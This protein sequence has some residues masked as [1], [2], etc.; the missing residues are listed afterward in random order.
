MRASFSFRL[1][2]NQVGEAFSNR[3]QVL[4]HREHETFL[5]SGLRVGD[6][7]TEKSGFLAQDEQF[8]ILRAR[9]PA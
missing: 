7:A 8:Q 5:A 6:L 9:R 2:P 3:S 1:W 4:E